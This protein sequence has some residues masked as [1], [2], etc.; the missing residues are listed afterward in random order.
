[1]TKG[2]G[3]VPG[4]GDLPKHIKSI[5]HRE[6]GQPANRRAARRKARVLRV[7]QLKRAAA[8]RNETKHNNN[9]SGGNNAKRYFADAPLQDARNLRDSLFSAVGSASASSDSEDEQQQLQRQQIATEV[10]PAQLSAAPASSRV[11]FGSVV[12][13]P[14]ILGLVKEHLS[15]QLMSV[16][17]EAFDEARQRA[18][19]ARQQADAQREAHREAFDEARKRADDAIDQRDRLQAELYLARGQLSKRWVLEMALRQAHAGGNTSTKFNATATAATLD[20]MTGDAAADIH[21]CMRKHNLSNDDVVALYGL[22]ST[23]IHNS[24]ADFESIR[25]QGNLT[26]KQHRFILCVA[27]KRFGLSI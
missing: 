20:R 5:A 6:R 16:L 3:K 7:M 2:K 19:E 9:D 21:K 8:L 13:Q 22:L 18:D 26:A 17:S 1:M 25:D 12:H 11:A 27:A 10:T 24:G 23:S 4:A 14:A 15:R